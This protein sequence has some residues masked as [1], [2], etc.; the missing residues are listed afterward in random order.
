VD[1]VGLAYDAAAH[2]MVIDAFTHRGAADPARFRAS[3]CLA[4]AFDG[5]APEPLLSTGIAELRDG[6]G[7][8]GAPN[9]SAEPPLKPYAQA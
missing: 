2:G 8:N 5:V 1:H 9:A 6:A 3:A 4:V 7:F